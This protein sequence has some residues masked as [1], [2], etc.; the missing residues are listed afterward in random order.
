MGSSSE[1]L[2]DATLIM[3]RCTLRRWQYANREGVISPLFDEA[4]HGLSNAEVESVTGP[5]RLT[6]SDILAN[7]GSGWECEFDG[8]GW[9]WFRWHATPDAYVSIAVDPYGSPQRGPDYYV[10]ANY[11]LM[12]TLHQEALSFLVRLAEVADV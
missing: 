5:P 7:P 10:P 12:V 4:G 3:Q 9:S 11:G 6:F 8:F 1:G 2:A